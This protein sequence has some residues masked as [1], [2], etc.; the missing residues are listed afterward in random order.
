ML[1][2]IQQEISLEIGVYVYVPA[3][4]NVRCRCDN[5]RVLFLTVGTEGTASTRLRVYNYL[6][7]LQANGIQT[8]VV[9][10]PRGRGHLKTSLWKWLSWPDV[11]VVQKATI[12]WVVK[13]ALGIFKR[14][15]I[16]DLDDA[17]F[18]LP[19]YMVPDPQKRASKRHQV[20]KMF[21]W[22]DYVIVSHEYLARYARQYNESVRILPMAINTSLF[23]PQSTNFKPL[24]DPPVLGWI[25]A[26]DARH[27][28][29]VK[30]LMEPLRCVAQQGPI[31]FRIVGIRDDPRFEDL[32]EDIPHLKV[33]T[34]SWLPPEAIPAQLQS[35]DIGLAPLIDDTWTRGKCPT[36]PLEYMASG[37]LTIASPVGAQT[38]FIEDGVNGFLASTADEWVSKI[39][40]VIRRECDIDSIRRNARHKV[41]QVY[42]VNVCADE[43]VAILRDAAQ[44]H[45]S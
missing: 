22:A 8:R 13:A 42:S 4:G 5:M 14:P 39:N 43:L 28:E 16:Y 27:F 41:E 44:C 45:R 20:D 37:V 18:A 40:R 36:K 2:I 35:I 32:F 25:G 12:S 38:D 23:R 10:V 17:L 33:E 34:I 31:R 11:V 19:D 1:D 15:R 30:I 26:A 21:Q 7:V 6:P 29:N 3:W 9:L 24:D